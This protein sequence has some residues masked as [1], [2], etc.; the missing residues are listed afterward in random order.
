M[1]RADY[2]KD[3]NVMYARCMDCRRKYEVRCSPLQWRL[4]T[5]EGRLIQDV[6]PRLTSGDREVFIS[7]ICNECYA[8][9]MNQVEK[10]ER[11]DERL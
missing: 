9:F 3:R 11:E 1:I 7:G 6:F 8:K 5:E 2:D 10:E 4:L